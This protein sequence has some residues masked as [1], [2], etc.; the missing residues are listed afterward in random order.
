MKGR[1]GV[2]KR[3]KGE[4]QVR[5]FLLSP[6]KTGLS[7]SLSHFPCQG[8]EVL[9]RSHCDPITRG[10]RG[11]AGMT[12]IS[13]LPTCLPTY[14]QHRLRRQ[15]ALVTHKSS[16]VSLMSLPPPPPPILPR[17]VPPP[18]QDE[19]GLFLLLLSAPGRNKRERKRKGRGGNPPPAGLKMG[20]VSPELSSTTNCTPDYRRGRRK[21][22]AE[23]GGS[24][25]AGMFSV[26]GD[27]SHEISRYPSPY[28]R[29]AADI[30]LPPCVCVSAAA[31]IIFLS[32]FPIQ[33]L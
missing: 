5:H 25:F 12:I 14:T 6:F 24:L 17:T 32:S 4:E 19:E 15:Y 27:P 16:R 29:H 33:T 11:K 30:R 7:L 23:E 26:R 1:T 13:E 21:Q 2:F 9:L 18:M 31:L 28:T 10:K 8:K 20:T 3:G 22:R